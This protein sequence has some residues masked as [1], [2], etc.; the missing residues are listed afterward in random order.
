MFQKMHRLNQYSAY[1]PASM[2]IISLR[3]L[4]LFK[5]Y[6]I[7]RKHRDDTH[8]DFFSRSGIIVAMKDFVF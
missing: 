3:V 8:Q 6:Q 7:K 4:W 2:L 5:K 1:A